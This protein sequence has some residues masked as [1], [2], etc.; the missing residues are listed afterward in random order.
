M[1]DNN[2][3]MAK[4][5]NSG[6][7]TDSSLILTVFIKQPGVSMFRAVELTLQKNLLLLFLDTKLNKTL[8]DNLFLLRTKRDKRLCHE[9]TA[10]AETGNRSMDAL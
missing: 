3:D 1:R 9:V 6:F 7:H 4:T 10:N 8:I 2:T 5:Q